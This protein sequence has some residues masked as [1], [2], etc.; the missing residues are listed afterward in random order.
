MTAVSREVHAVAIKDQNVVLES[1]LFTS[2]VERE[3]S[4]A[5]YHRVQVGVREG[6]YT[7]WVG[8]WDQRS[9]RIGECESLTALNPERASMRLRSGQSVVVKVTQDG[10]PVSLRGATITLG[11][12]FVGGRAGEI[13]PLVTASVGVAD[14]GTRR[15]LSAVE[16][17]M[18]AGGLA[19]REVVVALDDAETWPA[20]V[21]S[22]RIQRDST[23]ALS[24][25]QYEGD[26]V[27]VNGTMVGITS[28]GISLTTSDRIIDSTGS[29]SS[30]AITTSTLYYLYLGESGVLRAATTAPTRYNGI[31]YLGTTGGAVAWRF[32]GWA[33][34]NSSTQWVNDTTDRLVINYYNRLALPIYVRPGYS[35]GNTITT[36]TTTST[37]WTSANAGSGSAGSYIAN[38]ED[39][40]R[41]HLTSISAGSGAISVYSGIGDNSTTNAYSMTHS[42]NTTTMTNH[43]AM[44]YTPSAGYRTV[45]LLVAVSGGT[46]TFTADY[47]RLGGSADPV[48]T[49]IAGVVM[50]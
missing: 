46:G 44:I 33:R 29:F 30:T 13:R 34:T 23:T 8:E 28:S 1:A 19:R 26:R 50:G 36:Y 35:D 37:T 10:G 47:S 16:R 43:C 32:M 39:A 12:A 38:G 49:Q 6:E 31:Y 22:G 11:L 41:F 42:G 25:Q 18:N 20:G 15:A 40:V 24:L 3:K 2:L 9:Q 48:G 4:S 45:N 17:Q 21:M 14:Q 7:T 5:S 27:D